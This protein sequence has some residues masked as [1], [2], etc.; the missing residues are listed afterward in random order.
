MIGL[1][2][3]I[4][5]L[6]GLTGFGLTANPNPPTADQALAYALAD[7]DVAAHLDAASVV[8][9]NWRLL[10]QLA[11][12]PQ[13]KASPAL[14]RAVTDAVGKLDL[15]RASAQQATGLD[16]A[17]DISDATVFVQLVPSSQ[18]R[19]V[20][21]V[22][23]KFT[24]RNLDKIATK[25]GRAVTRSGTGSILDGGDREPALALTRD[26]VL[27]IGTAK[28][29][30]DRLGDGWVPPSH[31][32]GTSL[33]Y[34]ADAIRARPVFAV[35]LTMSATAR[36]EALKRLPGQGFTSDLVTRHKAAAFSVFRDGIGWTWLDSHA[37][38]LDAMELV[39]RGS[40]EVLRAAQVAPRGIAKIMMGAVESYR[41]VD[42]KL[43]ELI[44]HKAE[45]LRLVEN[46]TGDGNFKA[47]VDKHPKTLQLTVR[48]TGKTLSE[49]LP[50]GLF[51][52]AGVVAWLSFGEPRTAP[53]MREATSPPPQGPGPG[54]A[55]RPA[56]PPSP[57]PAPPPPAKR[58]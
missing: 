57:R 38:G 44:E 11:D 26:G 2:E 33:G 12:R 31:A 23:G 5:L 22:R 14:Q 37:A 45:L 39:V 51:L 21:A 43:D 50:L 16:L 27:L 42:P 9:G 1:V 15:A 7:P 36:G 6:L 54:G 3:I 55:G 47:T 30:R 49:V 56:R 48:A 8:P 29:V 17:A 53:V 46:Y 19:F 32:S 4:T 40:L 52:P 24:T 18:P 41:G 58:P 25:S 20:L 28:L 13:F 35:V 34:L 10:N